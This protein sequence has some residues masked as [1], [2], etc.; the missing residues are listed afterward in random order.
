VSYTLAAAAQLSFDPLAASLKGVFKK[1]TSK[2]LL[3][4][5]DVYAY[6]IATHQSAVNSQIYFN[7]SFQLGMRPIFVAK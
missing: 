7:G 4:S 3:C 6:F 1:K 2:R 5:K